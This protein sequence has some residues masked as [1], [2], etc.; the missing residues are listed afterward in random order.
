MPLQ[1]INL[2]DHINAAIDKMNE[3]FELLD[4]NISAL[5][6]DFLLALIT[7]SGL[8][9]TVDSSTIFS[10]I[11]ETGLETRM[12]S[13]EG[14]FS[15]IAQ[16]FTNLETQLTNDIAT[17]VSTAEQ[18]LTTRIDETDSSLSI[19]ASDVTN[20]ETQYLSAD[21]DI[22]ALST[23]QSELTSRIDV[24][25]SNVS[26][27]AQDLVDLE[28]QFIG[29][30]ELDSDVIVQAVGG[31]LSNLET[32]INANSDEINIVSQSVT[33][34]SADLS[35]LDSDLNEQLSINTTAISN[36]VTSAAINSDG[37]EAL[38]GRFDS[39]QVTLQQ[40]LDSGL[41]INPDDVA[42]AVG[43]ITDDLYTKIY[44]NSD[45]ISVVTADVTTLESKLTLLD[46]NGALS[47]VIATAVS[48]LRTD[49]E[50]ADD[51]NFSAI[52]SLRTDLEN[53]I[54]SD[55]QT[56]NDTLTNSYVQQGTLTQAIQDAR[57]LITQEIDGDVQTALT[58]IS[59]T[60]ETKNGVVTAIQDARTLI[61]QEINGSVA[62]AEQTLNTRID[63]IDVEVGYTLNLDA[64]GHVAGIQFNNDGATADMS[65]IA[66]KFGIVNASNNAIKPFTVD[67]D[68]VL[69][70]NAT[71]TGQLNISSTG[72]GG[73]MTM[74]NDV[75]KIF[76]SA[77]N[78]RVVFGRL[79]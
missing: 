78:T 40:A 32:R 57:T 56:I 66:D 5:D 27:L 6:S 35:V 9:G 76:D 36:L 45:K 47:D 69:L 13:I 70:S 33:D 67:G 64:N 49:V 15:L 54:D 74:T 42:A 18:S 77:G 4:S 46:S 19:V 75:M 43:G 24:T 60:Y 48:D 61:T 3:N 59:N 53:K 12:D 44:A 20:L 73:S 62:T 34:L 29:G 28:A 65:I 38:S 10:I 52:S 21:S 30:I 37:I 11:A 2:G 41:E 68:N 79:A 22:T 55:V 31:A 63:G 39:F 16:D 51:S 7:E 71:V 25:D 26:I 1:T 14:G 58:T 50:A 17:A 23:A 8:E 72:N